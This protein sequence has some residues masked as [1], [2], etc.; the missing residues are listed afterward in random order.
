MHVLVHLLCVQAALLDATNR[1]LK[2]EV[3]RLQV[4]RAL[5][6]PTPISATHPAPPHLTPTP[7]T[8]PH[9]RQRQVETDAATGAL[10]QTSA[11]KLLE[12]KNTL[13]QS[14][15]AEYQQYRTDSEATLKDS[16]AALAANVTGELPLTTQPHMCTPTLTL[17]RALS[18][19]PTS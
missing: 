18:S 12:E 15:V 10:A 5:L 13:M 1:N 6:I 11:N 8:H 14:L 3:A 4:R 9:H 17:P 2:D 7:R 19:R 16:S